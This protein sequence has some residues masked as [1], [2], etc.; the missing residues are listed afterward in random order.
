MSTEAS[1]S[2]GEAVTLFAFLLIIKLHLNW[3]S[4]TEIKK[5]QTK[6]P[7]LIHMLTTLYSK[8]KLRDRLG[9]ESWARHKNVDSWR[10]NQD[11]FFIRVWNKFPVKTGMLEGQIRN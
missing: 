11:E 1:I 9:A 4:R 7:R 6:M 10:F 2:A 3:Y 8:R 5:F